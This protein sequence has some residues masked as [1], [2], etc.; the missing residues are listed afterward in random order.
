MIKVPGNK[1]SQNNMAVCDWRSP[2]WDV[3]T[4]NAINVIRISDDEGRR[5]FALIGGARFAGWSLLR[6][7]LNLIP[8]AIRVFV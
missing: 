2:L 4:A 1:L 6:F 8:T 7:G 5:G 3:R